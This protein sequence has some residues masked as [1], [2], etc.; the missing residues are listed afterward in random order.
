MTE[1]LVIVG[2]TTLLAWANG[3]N[4]VSKGI[5]TL[6]GSGVTS[7]RRAIVWGTVWTGAGA[8]VASLVAGAMLTTFGSGLWTDGV[9]LSLAAAV[10]ALAGAGAWV[11]IATHTSLPVSTTHAL[12]GGVVGAGVAAY[13]SAG[14]AWSALGG[15]VV[16]PLLLSPLVAVVLAR[17]VARVIASGGADEEGAADCVCLTVEQPAAIA[18][19]AGSA[20]FLTGAAP[21]VSVVIG[22]AASCP[23]ARPRTARLTANHLHWLSSGAVSFARG[24][25]DAPKIV[26][27]A[28]AAAA[29]G[30][31]SP[32]VGLA[33]LFAFVT[34][35]MIAGSVL[36]GRAVTRVLA[37]DVTPMNHREGLAAN[38]VTAV[39]VTTGAVHGMPMSTTHVS[40][41]GIAGIGSRRGT[42]NWTTVRGV[43]LAWVITLPAAGVLGA[44][45]YAVARFAG[46]SG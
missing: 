30:V 45:A 1:M 17:L 19:G 6:V 32:A 10:A 41:S 28:L 22:H 25:N 7:Y 34:C 37:E 16:L 35:G 26:G 44:V 4:D 31:A 18:V 23:A 13:G 40:S 15:K 42:L 9:T 24:M 8:A 11:L 5:A 20:A 36:A 3:A 33:P 14:V 39:L 38:L 2:I 46:L 43:G 21:S 12:V 29:I 27:L